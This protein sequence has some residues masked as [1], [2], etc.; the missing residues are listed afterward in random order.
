[1]GGAINTVTK[2][3]GTGLGAVFTGGTSLIPGSPTKPIGDAIG[4]VLTGGYSGQKGPIPNVAGPGFMGGSGGGSM[5]APAIGGYE[6]PLDVLTQSGGAPL[7]MDI[8]L[9]V[10]PRMAI[11][12]HFGATGQWDDFVKNL[13]PE[14]AHAVIG[15]QNQLFKIQDNVDLQNQTVKKLADDYPNIM[16]QKIQQY[17][18]VADPAIQSM[19]KQAIDQISAKQAAGGMISSG[20]SAEAAAKAGASFAGDKLNYATGLAQNDFNQQLSIAQGLQAFQQKMLGQGATQGFSAV[21]N[22]LQR[23]AAK[24]LA[25]AGYTNEANRYNTGQENAMYGALGG[26][27]GTVLGGVFGGPTGAAVGGSLGSTLFGT[28]TAA[29]RLNFGGSAPRFTGVPAPNGAYGPM[30]DIQGA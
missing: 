16:T 28:P 4:N 12:T 18:N 25:V 20:A 10:D 2:G 14:D 15:L 26:L 13:S 3:I 11:M 27:G 24:D 7:L 8:S 19:M 23:N 6:R 5:S 29:P 17:S 1:M 22:A 21:Q 9:G 30:G